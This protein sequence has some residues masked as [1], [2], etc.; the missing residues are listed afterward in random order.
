MNTCFGGVDVVHNLTLKLWK[1]TLL[2]CLNL[3]E[4]NPPLNPQQNPA[5]NKS[6]EL[7]VFFQIVV[8]ITRQLLAIKISAGVI[9]VRVTEENN[10]RGLLRDS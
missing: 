4:K 5:R 7:V 8:L 6:D 3:I 9:Y 1:L 2:I 10:R